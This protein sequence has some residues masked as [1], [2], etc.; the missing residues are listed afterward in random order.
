MSTDLK[1][2]FNAVLPLG[3]D[4]RVDRVEA[5]P[6]RVIVWLAYHGAGPIY[7][8]SEARYW[9]HLDTVGVGTFLAARIPR[10]RDRE[11][12]IRQVDVP[13]ADDYSRYTTSFECQILTELLANRSQSATARLLGISFSV[14]HQVMQ[15]AVD[16][17]ML[18]RGDDPKTLR[19]LSLDEKH[20][21]T[22]GSKRQMVTVLSDPLHR[23]VLEVMPGRTKA[24]AIKAIT[25]SIPVQGRAAVEAVS[26]DMCWSYHAAVEECLPRALVVLDKFHLSIQLNTAVDHTR[27]RE[28]RH[29]ED[30]KG[31]RFDLMRSDLS[32]DRKAYIHSLRQAAARTAEVWKFKE[33]FRS[34]YQCRDRA[35]AEIYLETW[36]RDAL[37]EPAG[38]LNRVATTFTRFKTKI[39]NFF[40]HPI[41]NARAERFNGWI[42]QLRV[43]AKGFKSFENF[44]TA[45]LFFFGNL[46][47][48]PRKSV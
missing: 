19:Y 13:W 2:F 1:G 16:R 35:E 27:R 41:T 29:R 39:L 8:Q 31:L 38:F 11:G 17:G 48:Y 12:N 30:L 32:D 46:D 21:R 22:S 9:R 26:A 6:E 45:V 23:R 42:Q 18:R 36:L 14:V 28:S 33:D 44:R 20:Y 5:G 24:A 7:D 15:R 25:A 3:R 34:L 37:Q 40:D 47:L 10:V 43:Q 4:W